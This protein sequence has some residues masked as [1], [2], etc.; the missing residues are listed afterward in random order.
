[1]KA[2]NK[3]T[4][5]GGILILIFLLLSFLGCGEKSEKDKPDDHKAWY[6]KGVAL[7]RLGR[8][9]DALKAYK[10]AKEISMRFRR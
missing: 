7:L 10:K 6:N 9:D 2:T 4:I 8:H 3:K 5:Y 1:M